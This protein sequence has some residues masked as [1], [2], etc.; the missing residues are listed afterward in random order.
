MIRTTENLQ[1]YLN[2]VI[3]SSSLGKEYTFP[4]FDMRH[5]ISIQGWIVISD[6]K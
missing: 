6:N 5:T 4:G 2:Q 1:D 3:Q